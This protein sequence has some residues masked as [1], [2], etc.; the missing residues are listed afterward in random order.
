MPIVTG[1]C[2]SILRVRGKRVVRREAAPVVYR[3]E[4]IEVNPS[5]VRGSE[6]VNI[7]DKIHEKPEL[8]RQTS[9]RA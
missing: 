3:Q 6:Y 2:E 4:E 5:Q 8:K 9:F 7:Q 1:L